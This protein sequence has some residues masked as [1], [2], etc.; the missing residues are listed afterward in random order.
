M[1]TTI[2]R[3]PGREEPDERVTGA[4]EPRDR[5]GERSTHPTARSEAFRWFLRGFGLAL[6]A[7]VIV[8]FAAAALAA[9]RV[10]LMVFIAMLIAS[11]LEPIVAR[12]RIIRPLPR[13]GGILVVYVA[14]FGIVALLGLVIVPG[15]IDQAGALSKALPEEIDRL[16]SW[17]AGIQPPIVGSTLSGILDSFT[18]LGAA[19]PPEPGQ[20][21]EAGITVADAVISIVTVLALVFFWMTERPRLIRYTLSFVPAGRRG[22]A[23]DAWNDVELRLGRWFRGQLVLMA[24]MAVLSTI[25]YTILGL[26]GALLLGVIAGIAEFI[27]LIGPAIGAVPALLVAAALRPEVL[28]LTVIAYVAIHFLEG[29]VLVPIVMRNAVGVSPFVVI[30]SLLVGSAIDGWLGALL[31]VPTFAA[32][33]AVLERLQDRDVPVAQDPT[34]STTPSKEDVPDPDAVGSLDEPDR[35]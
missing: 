3:S 20:L 7:L 32:V 16:R 8:A 15:A 11:A 28:V 4:I 33:E 2:L 19:K 21:V 29:N 1:A 26:P 30:V 6:G 12:F 25:A 35:H 14:F 13:G 10:I 22:G 27:P 24:I 31:A 9:V 18:K 23:R 5:P 17:V 34:A